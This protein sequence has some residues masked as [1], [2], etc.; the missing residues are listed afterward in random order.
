MPRG[1]WTS[2]I[3]D[4]K[5]SAADFL[6]RSLLV[7]TA[8]E[9]TDR[10]NEELRKKNRHQE[11]LTLYS[12]PD[13]VSGDT[14]IPFSLLWNL[15]G[16][17][18]WEPHEPTNARV[19]TKGTGSRLC[20]LFFHAVVFAEFSQRFKGFYFHWFWQQREVIFS[21]SWWATLVVVTGF[22]WPY[23]FS[24]WNLGLVNFC[25]PRSCLLIFS[26][27]FVIITPSSNN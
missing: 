20:R 1:S 5:N 10:R 24:L 25:I 2:S 11:I 6:L 26:C 16:Y 18:R 12:A 15:I 19:C 7:R 22:A 17:S 8:I 14:E 13:E 27:L 4:L 21:K 23:I 3:F 9:E